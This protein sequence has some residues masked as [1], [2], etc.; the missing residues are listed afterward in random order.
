[1]YIYIYHPLYKRHKQNVE[2]DLPFIVNPGDV[3]T[4][5]FLAA[6]KDCLIPWPSRPQVSDNR[7]CNHPVPTLCG[8]KGWTIFSDL[9]SMFFFVSSLL[10]VSNT[11]W[12]VNQDASTIEL[13]SATLVKKNWT[14][15]I[16]LHSYYI[17]INIRFIPLYINE[18]R[19]MYIHIYMYTHVYYYI[20]HQSPF[21]GEISSK[22]PSETH[23][24]QRR[25][26]PAVRME[27]SKPPRKREG[28]RSC[29][30]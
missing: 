1:M 27:E 10:E 7:Y 12:W 8:G 15:H 13:E 17:D 21:R 20:W 24:W 3:K 23:G 26:R 18:Y 5:P 22:P 9:R 11:N 30:V 28:L 16:T 19:H 25:P 4:R 29:K 6:L 14:N 2:R